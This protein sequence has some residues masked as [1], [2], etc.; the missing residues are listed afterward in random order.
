MR[1]LRKR[2]SENSKQMDSRFGQTMSLTAAVEVALLQ[3]DNMPPELAG[4]VTPGKAR[5]T[6]F[7]QK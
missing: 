6:S 7:V 3:G 4:R 5:L 1:N 2:F